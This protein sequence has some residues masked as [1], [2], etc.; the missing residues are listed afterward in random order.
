ML[1]N[2]K[3]AAKKAL[4]TQL[5]DVNHVGAL[6]RSFDS[7]GPDSVIELNDGQRL[8]CGPMDDAILSVRGI[9]DGFLRPTL[10][11]LMRHMYPHYDPSRPIRTGLVPRRIYPFLH[12]QHK[13]TFGDL[14]MSKHSRAEIME[15][16]KVRAGDQVL[17][18]GAYLGL[19]TRKIARKVGSRGKVVSVEAHHDAQ[20]V[21]KLN[22]DNEGLGNASLIEGALSDK[23][24]MA[25]LEVSSNQSTTLISGIIDPERF[26]HVPEFSLASV[27]AT[28]GLKPDLI[29]LTINGA[30]LSVLEASRELLVSLPRCRVITPGWYSDQDGLLGPRIVSLLQ[31]LG[32]KVHVTPGWHVFASAHR[33][34]V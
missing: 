33:G 32:F 18:A 4:L 1:K 10:N 6:I 31:H 13:N 9:P 2:V 7:Q 17:E 23:D 3:A 30:E 34:D 25:T 11:L 21:W 22:L 27:L 19:G 29:V 12:P 5:F 24:G 8:F 28:T 14:K 20:R 26:F 15:E 16:F